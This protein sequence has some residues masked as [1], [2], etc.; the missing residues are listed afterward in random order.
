MLIIARTTG[1][2]T[3]STSGCYTSAHISHF[4]QL[5]NLSTLDEPEWCWAVPW[6]SRCKQIIVIVIQLNSTTGTMPTT[7]CSLFSQPISRSKEPRQLLINQS[8][9]P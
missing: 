8:S 3:A 1:V 7:V 5:Y 2:Q 9:E 6:H 4:M